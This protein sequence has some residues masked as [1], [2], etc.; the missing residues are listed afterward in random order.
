M[1]YFNNGAGLRTP[2]EQAPALSKPFLV[3]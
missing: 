3:Q 2:N 1:D